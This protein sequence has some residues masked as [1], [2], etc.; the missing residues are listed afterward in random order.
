MTAAAV[1]IVE[2]IGADQAGVRLSSPEHTI[3]A[4]TAR[5]THGNNQAVPIAGRA[6]RSCQVS[7]PIRTTAASSQ[8]RHGQ[9][10]QAATWPTRPAGR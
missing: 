2:R 5:L 9:A 4:G 10:T 7:T 3:K 6:G 1:P 8:A